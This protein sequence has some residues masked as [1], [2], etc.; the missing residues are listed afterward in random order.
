L[1][2]T[3]S[4]GCSDTAWS[5]DAEAKKQAEAQYANFL[6]DCSGDKIYVS[7]DSYSKRPIF[8]AQLR[9]W[10]LKLK[11][12]AL[13]EADKLNGVSWSGEAEITWKL[14][15]MADYPQSIWGD[16]AEG[17]RWKLPAILLELRKGKWSH[18]VVAGSYLHPDAYSCPV[19][20]GVG[21]M[22]KDQ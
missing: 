5:S 17:S 14:V 6:K 2:V 21:P 3:L 10:T 13:S 7:V 11:P 22:L 12:R 4:S 15:R 9:D 16:W 19:G 18:R 1:A 20:A 8:A